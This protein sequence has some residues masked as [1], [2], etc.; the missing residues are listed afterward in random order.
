[1]PFINIGK[2]AKIMKNAYKLEVQIGIIGDSF[3]IHTGALTVRYDI[4][5]APKKLLGIIAELT[6]KIPSESGMWSYS[7]SHEET[8]FEVTEE[9]HRYLDALL[10]EPAPS[11]LKVSQVRIRDF[12]LLQ[13]VSTS[14]VVAIK[15]EVIEMLDKTKV[16]YDIEGDPTGPGMSARGLV[17]WGN[18][19][20]TVIAHPVPLEGKAKEIAD[21][22]ETIT[23][24]NEEE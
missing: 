7:T 11:T 4:A 9:G 8:P 23:L 18:S 15:G 22:L 5:H 12:A 16:E 2:L 21:Y 3:L 17:Y 10:Y 1:M 6:G 13:K 24:Y 20:C 19:L 14:E